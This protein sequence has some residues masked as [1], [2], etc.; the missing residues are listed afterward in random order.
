MTNLLDA[1]AP[2]EN[3]CLAKPRLERH[4]LL[5][6]T[7]GSGTTTRPKAKDLGLCLRHRLAY[8]YWERTRGWVDTHTAQERVVRA[9]PALPHGDLLRFIVVDH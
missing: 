3:T 7:S 4:W 2:P 5:Q 6:E 8:L 9:I 1:K